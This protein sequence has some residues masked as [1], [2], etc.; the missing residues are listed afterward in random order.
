M[1]GRLD[2]LHIALQHLLPQHLLSAL[3]YRLTR[4]RVPLLRNFL[5]HRFIHSFRVDMAEARSPDPAAYDSFNDFFTRALRSD[6]RPLCTAANSVVSPVDGQVS[7]AA[8]IH[9][10]RL[11]Q[12]KGRDYSVA[13]LLGGA[14]R[15]DPA[16][17]Q[18]GPFV[19]LYL[20][21]RD[22]HRIHMPVAARL[23]TAVYVPGA[24]FP[25]NRVS[26]E[27]VENLFAR[28]E[29]LVLEFAGPFGSMILCMVGAIFV[30]S[31]ETVWHGQVTPAGDRRIRTL[32]PIHGD[33]AADCAGGQEIARFNMGS[34]VILLFERDV[35]TWDTSLAPGSTVRMGQAIG[36][37]VA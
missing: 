2:S 12:A 17:Y 20:S 5:I 25:V 8:D 36:R 33:V 31:M 28:N 26:T 22:Y 37:L 13:A 34:T 10:G 23:R 24:L 3:A 14:A 30:G 18:G 29:R 4:C 7:Q 15:P 27:R 32:E 21:P 1:G 9:D 6:A 35:V 16:R 11:I 19:T